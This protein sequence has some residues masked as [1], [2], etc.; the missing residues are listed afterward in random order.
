V[1]HKV[2]CF[3][4][5]SFT[6]DGGRNERNDTNQGAKVD[7]KGRKNPGPPR[8]V[9]VLVVVVLVVVVLVVVVFLFMVFLAL[10]VRAQW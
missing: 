10:Q 5:S 4:R 3:G 7:K 1:E 6:K 8:R 9:A 2:L